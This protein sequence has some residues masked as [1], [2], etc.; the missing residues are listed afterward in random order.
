MTQ[1][2]TCKRLPTCDEKK[3]IGIFLLWM[4]VSAIVGAIC[5]LDSGVPGGH[6][7]FYWFISAAILLVTGLGLALIIWLFTDCEDCEESESPDLS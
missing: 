2:K 7:F 4:V 3:L 5:N 1:E 6:F